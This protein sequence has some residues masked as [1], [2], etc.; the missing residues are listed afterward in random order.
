MTPPNIFI[1]GAGPQIATAVAKI[2]A[3]NG[4]SIGL[5]SRSQANLQK[6]K[7]L[8]PEGTKVALAV[9]DA[10]DPPSCVKALDSLKNDLGAPSVV[11]W[12]AGSLPISFPTKNLVE[13]TIED[14]ERH[15]RLNVVAGFAVVQWGVKNVVPD[16]EGRSLV[17]ITGGA[18]ALQPL[19]G[20]SGLSAG[21]AGLLNLAKAFRV[22]VSDIRVATVMVS[23]RVDEPNGDPFL[24]SPVI[25][26]EY[27][28]LYTQ[29]KEDWTYE[30]VH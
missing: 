17:F 27:W 1:I 18:L 14:M 23:G 8:L 24:S 11:V 19:A 28:K 29:K 20:L 30:V 7:A 4:F 6:Y 15:M 5:S 16:P 3:S 13:M 22:E 2:F 10:D 21:K 25:A 12:N 26:E 9:S